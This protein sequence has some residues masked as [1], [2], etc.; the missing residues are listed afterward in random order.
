MAARFHVLQCRLIGVISAA[1]IVLK[2][3]FLLEAGKSGS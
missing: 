3:S 1:L 2:C